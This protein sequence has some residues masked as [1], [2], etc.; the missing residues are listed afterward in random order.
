MAKDYSRKLF[1]T[2]M[3]NK[4]MNQEQKTPPIL[5]MAFNRPEATKK[6]FQKIR[7]AKP[8]RLFFAVDGARNTKE[9]RLVDQVRR[10]IKL[11]DWECKVK[12]LFR[13]ENCGLKDGIIKNINW[14]FKNVEEGIILEDDCLADSSFFRF[15]GELL[16]KYRDDERIMHISGSNPHKGWRRDKY[17]YYFSHYTLSWGWATWRRA[18]EKIELNTKLYKEIKNKGYTKDL[19]PK[20][21]ERIF[22]QRGFDAV[23]LNNF[24]VWDHQ[25]LFTPAINSALAIIPNKNLVKNIGINAEGTNTTSL[26]DNELSLPSTKINFPLNHPPFTIRDTVSDNRYARKMF[27]RGIIN[28]FLRAIHISKFLKK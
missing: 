6:V 28:N 22:V 18:W 9:K 13:E 2:A 10:V 24:K 26:L 21:H 25:W 5:L 20:W 12:T 3:Q 11:V 16:E 7:E 4:F 19:Y 1:N 8:K 15:C 17:S 27:R 14:F 23:Y